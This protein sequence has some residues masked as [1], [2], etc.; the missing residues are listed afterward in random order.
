MI[1]WSSA[2]L[3]SQEN[4]FVE[5][6]KSKRVLCN[7]LSM[8]T[9]ACFVMA[10]SL[11]SNKIDYTE[12]CNLQFIIKLH[13][14]HS[15]LRFTIHL[16]C[17]LQKHICLFCRRESVAVGVADRAAASRSSSLQV[18]RRWYQYVHQPKY[19]PIQQQWRHRS[20]ILWTT[21]SRRHLLH[22]CLPLRCLI[23]RR[24]LVKSAG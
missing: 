13:N 5:A 10:S 20:M 1:F 18:V 17:L 19:L 3:N 24:L 23:Q 15:F 14:K 8:F 9:K 7:K 22:A 11:T 12:N 16:Y 2:C 4:Y 21:Y 6:T